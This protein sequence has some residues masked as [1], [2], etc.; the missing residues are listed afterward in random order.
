MYMYVC[1]YVFYN[2]SFSWPVYLYY[3]L[4]PPFISLSFV[5]YFFL[6]LCECSTWIHSA[7]KSSKLIS[8]A[9]VG[10]RCH[11]GP[12][13]DAIWNPCETFSAIQLYLPSSRT[14]VLCYKHS[15]TLRPPGSKFMSSENDTWLTF[16]P[17]QVDTKDTHT[18]TKHSNASG[19]SRRVHQLG[20]LLPAAPTAP[21]PQNMQINY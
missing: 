10:F 15:L 20:C 7:I 14:P 2:W 12:R 6:S 13:A 17:G 3:V 1:I 9:S 19:S 21:A 5:L 11:C 4:K 16:V 18:R 8:C